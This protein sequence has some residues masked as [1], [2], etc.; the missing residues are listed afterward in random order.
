MWNAVVSMGC[1]AALEIFLKAGG[2]LLENIDA[3]IR[4]LLEGTRKGIV[5]G[6][7]FGEI[8]GGAMEDLYKFFGFGEEKD[9]EENHAENPCLNPTIP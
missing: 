3:P 8:V 5:Y 7:F 2:G 9:G 1:I 6:T 4:E